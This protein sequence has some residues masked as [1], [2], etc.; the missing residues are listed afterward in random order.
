MRKFKL[1]S[2]ENNEGEFQLIA[3]DV[4][5]LE[6]KGKKKGPRF[7][8]RQNP[9]D[10]FDFGFKIALRCHGEIEMEGESEHMLGSYFSVK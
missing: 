9:Q 3:I 7:E 6:P 4:R 10:F 2:A 8:T 5:E 1:Y